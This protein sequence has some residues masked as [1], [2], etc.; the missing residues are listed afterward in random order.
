MEVLMI[1]IVQQM[2]CTL[3]I[4]IFL[5]LRSGSSE[6]VD[7][8]SKFSIMVKNSLLIKLSVLISNMTIVYFKF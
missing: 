3:I 4:P 8:M 6:K 2:C 5:L 7:P 1:F